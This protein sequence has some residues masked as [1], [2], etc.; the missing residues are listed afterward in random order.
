ML[1]GV[2]ERGSCGGEGYLHRRISDS[3]ATS[4]LPQDMPR[5]LH[6]LLVVEAAA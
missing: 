4:K 3:K 2:A 1:R 5:Q 6:A